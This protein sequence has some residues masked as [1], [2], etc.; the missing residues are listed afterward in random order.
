[1]KNTIIIILAIAALAAG[2]F[3]IVQRSK[4]RAASSQLTEAQTRL[5]AAETQL[6][7]QADA[8][9]HARV[10][11]A[12]TTILQKTLT[13]ASAEAVQQSKQ[14]EQ[15]KQTLAAAKTNNPLKGI[16]AMFKSPEMR[17]MMEAQQKAVMG[18][19]IS[20]QYSALCQQL[21][22]TPE[23]ADAFKTLLQNKQ[24]ASADTGLSM[25]DDSLD[26][27]QRASL[28]AQ[29]K[30]Q[31]DDFDNQIK[32]LLG[33]DNYQA[34]QDY[35]KTIPARTTVNQ[36]MDQVAGTPNALSADQQEQLVQAMTEANKNFQWTSALNP[37]S[38]EAA[39]HDPMAQMALLTEDNINQAAAETEKFDQQ[40]LSKAQQ[41]LT[42][43]QTTAFQ[44][45]QTTWRQMQFS[46]MKMAAGMFSHGNQGNQ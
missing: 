21:N 40:F 10:S 12:K 15:L 44:Q 42:P 5:A 31:N 6:K 30:S 45:F 4:S 11:E 41:I 14:T 34:Y 22:L 26:A 36:F 2:A 7:Q 18:P 38:N 35:N 33:S 43:E 1:M 20:K 32:Q 23:Q 25:L 3:C 27:A 16:A 24:L 8:V 29:I 9:E 19:M 37:K 28:E 13:E 46:T 17:K 39:K